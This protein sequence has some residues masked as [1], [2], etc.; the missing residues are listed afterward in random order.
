M[1]LLPYVD[2]DGFSGVKGDESR[3]RGMVVV[4]EFCRGDG[5]RGIRPPAVRVLKSPL[6]D[7]IGVD[8]VADAMVM[9]DSVCIELY[10]GLRKEL[11]FSGKQKRWLCIQSSSGAGY[12]KASCTLGS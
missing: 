12:R 10:T 11:K 4:L 6:W 8:T 1:R 2:F 5:V 3:F 9:S 7:L